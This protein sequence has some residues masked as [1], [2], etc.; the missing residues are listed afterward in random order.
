MPTPDYGIW[1]WAIS[2]I[3]DS[4]PVDGYGHARARLAFNLMRRQVQTNL[5]LQ[6][7]GRN[8]AVRLAVNLMRIVRNTQPYTR[9]R[10]CT[11]VDGYDR[12]VKSPLPGPG[13]GPG[14]ARLRRA[15]GQSLGPFPLPLGA[16]AGD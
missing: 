7:L 1:I 12:E 13:P 14:R 6:Y 9:A 15:L 11:P 3:W 2:R 4:T 16:R 8:A 5:S 10:A